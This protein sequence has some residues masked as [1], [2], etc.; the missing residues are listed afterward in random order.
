MSRLRRITKEQIIQTACR[1]FREQGYAGT[2]LDQVAS[3]LGVTRAALYYWVSKKESLLCEIH[4]QVMA[5]LLESFEAILAGQSDEKEKLAEIIRNHALIVA[6]NLDAITVFFQDRPALP[7][8]AEEHMMA[9]KR[10]YD[11]AVEKVVRA[12]QQKGMLRKDLDAK[13]VVK[14]LIGMCNWLHQW[15]GPDGPMSAEEIADQMVKI[16]MSALCPVKQ[17]AY[18][19]SRL[20]SQHI[21]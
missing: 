13:I 15:Y 9:K 4:E 14:S 17:P 21:L 12:G 11:Q 1:L 5:A 2:T 16:A 6:N 19:V 8:E 3:E 18:A 10:D 20:S 7:R